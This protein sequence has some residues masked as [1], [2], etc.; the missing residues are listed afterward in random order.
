M[1][2]TF[3]NE[4]MMPINTSTFSER[5]LTSAFVASSLCLIYVDDSNQQSIIAVNLVDS[6]SAFRD[7]SS[8]QAQS[9]SRLRGFAHLS[10]LYPAHPLKKNWKIP[11]RTGI[12]KRIINT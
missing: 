5:R 9:I 6:A 4:R 2:S 7:T 8:D 11:S 12:V 1:S 3:S 10:S